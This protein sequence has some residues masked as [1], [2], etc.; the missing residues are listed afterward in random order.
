MAY[1]LTLQFTDMVRTRSGG[2]LDAWL[3]SVKASPLKEFH[4][5]AKSLLKD[6]EAVETGL[7]LPWSN[8]Q[9]EG[10][11]PTSS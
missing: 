5:F 7:I 10:R 8:G 6:I 9:T 3:A 2:K 11:L 1:E 4:P